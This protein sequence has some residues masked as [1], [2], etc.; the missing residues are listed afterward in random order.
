[1]RDL[2]PTE[3]HARRGRRRFR[4]AEKQAD[5]KNRAANNG[6]R[7]WCRV[8]AGAALLMGL[9]TRGRP[10]FARAGD[11]D[12]PFGSNGGVADAIASGSA[13][14]RGLVIQDG[15]IVAAGEAS[16]GANLDFALVRYNTDGSRDGTFGVGGLVLTP[17]GAGDDSA[18]A[19]ALQHDGKLI[20][21][22]A[23]S[24]GGNTD[25]ALV[26][27]NSVDGSLDT[28]FG[29]GGKVTTDFAGGDDAVV[30]VIVQDEKIVAVGTA[31]VGGQQVFALARYNTDGS[32]DTTFGQDNSDP[33]KGKTGLQ[34]TAFGSSPIAQAN[35]AILQRDDKIVVGGSVRIGACVDV[36][37]SDFAL[38]RYNAVDGSLDGGFGSG[39]TLTTSFGSRLDAVNALVLQLDDKIV[40]VG[41]AGASAV[42][43]NST[44]AFARYN[45]D[46]TLDTS[47]Q[48]TGK[49]AF[50]SGGPANAAVLQ[51]DEKVVAVGVS[52]STGVDQFAVARLRTDGAL[53]KPTF[54]GSGSELIGVGVDIA[55]NA[56]VLQSDG[57]VVAAGSRGAGASQVFFLVRYLADPPYTAPNNNALTCW[58]KVAS[59]LD[60]L[61]QCAI[62]CQQN[63]VRNPATFDQ[64]AC[65]STCRAKYDK[66]AGK[67][68]ASGKCPMCLDSTGQSRLADK[69]AAYVNGR[70]DALF[71]DG[72]EPLAHPFLSQFPMPTAGS[73]LTGIAQG[74]DSN[75]WFTERTTGKIGR[76]TP[77]GTVT[78]F[79]LSASSAPT[80]I[81]VGPDG[82]LWFTEQS[83]GKIGRITPS[84]TITE[85]AAPG[86]LAGP[87]GIVA[88]SDGNL[89]FAAQTANAIGRVNVAF[90]NSSSTFLFSRFAVANAPVSITAGADNRLWF[91]ESSIGK[92]GRI[93][94]TGTLAEFGVPTTSS[95]PDTIVSGPDGNLWFTEFAAN[96]IGQIKPDGTVTE[97]AVPGAGG[98]RGITAGADGNLW[99]V[100]STLGLI[101]R[102]TPA[103]VFSEYILPNS[104][105]QPLAIT[106]ALDGSLWFTET[107]IDKVGKIGLVG[108]GFQPP[109]AATAACEIAVAK[110]LGNLA[111]CVVKCE[112]MVTKANFK[113][114]TFDR[115]ACETTDPFKSC[116][117]KYNSAVTKLVLVGGCPACLQASEMAVQ[118]DQFVQSLS[119][120]QNDLFC[121]DTLSGGM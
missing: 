34:T 12:L 70:A 64:L 13:T 112:T 96:K 60:K 15:K 121:G 109:A 111:K 86:S 46:G 91:T 82:N 74:P 75:F 1:M 90:L 11:L 56:A 54:G 7:R 84:G 117:A 52:G 28:S 6:R 78:E 57:K 26:R 17:I 113:G 95:N 104:A 98:P 81:T 31:V 93:S 92:I 80:G 67:L 116:A 85:Y 24:N 118:R 58:T 107:A 77:D 115:A 41:E 19:L 99:F 83:A 25:F 62:T 94:V 63:A 110:N 18:R 43:G 100:E 29:S 9:C 38:A 27:Y 10:A 48:R 2:Q 39:G 55:A 59:G 66:S 21:A 89:W 76:L 97:F 16:N 106:A 3:V 108:G 61:R 22:G 36:C 20:A 119:D 23:V 45:V 88:G 51:P 44:F 72:T 73:G 8:V 102:V 68:V 4:R 65:V 101:G 87:N 71:C 53:D 47:F 5:A 30:A 105:S 69:A 49:V 79:A 33:T 120:T 114:K 35:A 32:L 50:A 37:N 103:G 14:I 42:L 40:A